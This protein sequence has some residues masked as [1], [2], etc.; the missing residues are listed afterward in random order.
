MDVTF[1]ENQSYYQKT[2]IQGENLQECNF[3]LDTS[4]L[5]ETKSNTIIEPNTS[6]PL[7]TFISPETEPNT[8][9]P[10]TESKTITE[11]VLHNNPN[12]VTVLPNNPD[13]VTQVHIQPAID[14]ELHV[15]SRR[16]RP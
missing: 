13:P 3:W 6:I 4:I 16:K 2:H 1:F 10:E 15:Y 11:I 8:I 12:P 5:L 9:S 7:N 14:N